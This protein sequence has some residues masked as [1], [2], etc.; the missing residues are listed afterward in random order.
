MINQI[1]KNRITTLYDQYKKLVKSKPEAVREIAIAEIPEMVYNSNAIENSTLTL[2]DTED[3]LLR[4]SIKKD[5]DIREIYEAKNLAKITEMLLDNTNSS[6]TVESMLEFHK[7]LLGGINDGWAGRL[8]SGKEWVRVGAHIGANPDFVERLIKELTADYSKDTHRYFL[9]EI[10]WFHAEFE[11]IHPFNDGNGRLGRVLV[12]QQLMYLGYPPIIIPNKGK[13]TSYYPAFDSYRVTAKHGDFTELFASLLIESL[14]KRITLL[15]APKVI[16]VSAW[17][18][19]NNVAGNVAANKA[20][21]G[22][23]PA[24]RMREKWMI[25][26]D[27][28]E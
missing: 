6:V 17:A 11:T 7:I 25:A 19:A 5:H 1:T 21:R 18:K 27:F 14:Y 20:S 24:F 26:A 8:R 10:A 16:T 4:D 28:T 15:S 2:K 22:T 12:N 13:H 3:I 23:I 9:D